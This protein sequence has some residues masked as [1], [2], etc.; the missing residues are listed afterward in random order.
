M[1]D[2]SLKVGFDTAK[3]QESVNQTNSILTKM[4]SSIQGQLV[5]AFSIDRGISM[6]TRGVTNA[7][8]SIAK[9]G[10]EMST[11]KAITGATGDE[12]E[13]L[14][15][16]AL[17]LG[18]AFKSIDIAKMEVELGRLGFS[19]EEILNSTKTSVNLAIASGEDLGKSA[20]IAGSTLRSFNLTADQMG[21][22]GDVMAASFNKSALG[23]SDFGEA[24]K[25][26]APVA[27]AAGL[28][29]EQVSAM[30]GVLADNGIKGSM[31]G[32]SLR[33]IISDLGQGAGPILTKELEKMAKAGISGSQ[34]MDEVGRTA[35][36][37]LLIL[38]NNT[39]KVTEATAAYTK[40]N[41]ELQV[42]SD[43]IQDNLLGDWQKLGAEWDRIVQ[44]NGGGINGFLRE[45][46]QNMRNQLQVWGSNEVSIWEKI[47]GSEKDYQDYV[48]RIN[49]ATS[50]AKTL[51]GLVGQVTN[52]FHPLTPAEMQAL[53]K[54]QNPIKGNVGDPYAINMNHLMGGTDALNPGAKT[55]EAWT[56]LQA[57]IK[58]AGDATSSMDKAMAGLNKEVAAA[59][60]QQLN[61]GFEA[62][63]VAAQKWEVSMTKVTHTLR[64]A[65]TSLI[66]GVGK[67]IGD[68][69]SGIQGAGLE[70][71]LLNVV[72]GVVSN[73][74]MLAI[75]IGVGLLG[76]ETAL[77]TLNP[78][79][80]IAA[81]VALVALGS[82][83]SNQA[84][85]L[86][87]AG[88]GGASA[89]GG[90]GS[91]RFADY[92]QAP[93]DVNINGTFK[94]SGSDLVSV[95]NKQNYNT[96]RVGG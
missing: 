93:I 54:K 79:V 47:F 90:G 36:A 39:T 26:V 48:K 49:F 96:G 20:Q 65:L 78:Y 61:A 63:D 86:G 64:N 29:L 59:D 18:G 11:L 60:I 9:F 32:T 34:A 7:V 5:A 16:N 83:F 66:A 12:F 46:T 17:S 55:V 53:G 3:F 52:A 89:A 6:F 38:A 35:Y 27:A 10:R 21:R 14:R 68:L 1:N 94:A 67:A 81:G 40:A 33:K 50:S 45:L 19:T 88:G 13:Q 30:L 62:A 25:Y 73:L 74:G 22:V 15:N 43:I 70:S 41:G 57:Q 82:Y 71:T 24:I 58:L 31:A 91:G 92:K 28:S 23:L 72:G 77:K 75:E 8:E 37:S 76:I 2:V 95:I 56:N 80:A 4:S 42:M 85:A 69:M 51:Q 87:S 44:G 84:S